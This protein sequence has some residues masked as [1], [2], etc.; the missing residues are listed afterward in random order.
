MILF[1]KG[2]LDVPSR[3]GSGQMVLVLRTVFLKT[4]E[5]FTG[6]K[7]SADYHR[8]MNSHHF[9]CWRKNT[10]LDKLLDQSVVVNDNA[11]YHSRQMKDSKKPTTGRTK[12]KIQ[13]WLAERGVSFDPKDTIPILL[14]KYKSFCPKKISARRYY[15]KILL[16]N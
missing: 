11:K 4:D 16:S 13:K 6:K 5:C 9:E 12:A 2:G 7:D 3:S 8:E 10:L 1:E 14:M 15:G